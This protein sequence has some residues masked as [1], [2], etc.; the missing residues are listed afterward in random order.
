[1][2]GGLLQPTRLRAAPCPAAVRHGG[3]GISARGADRPAAGRRDSAGP[4]H[5]HDAGRR[6]RAVLQGQGPEAV[7]RGG[8]AHLGAPAR[9]VRPRHTAPGPDGLSDRR[10]PGASARGRVR[11]AEGQGRQAS[12]PLCGEHQP[13]ARATPAPPA[14]RARGVG[15]RPSRRF[16][17]RRSRRAAF[18]GSN[19][20]RSAG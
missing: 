3:G 16:G 14:A 19:P 9:G 7:P 10:L 4:R 2:G 13:P 11:Q 1:V 5:G 18:G 20:T 12:A 15:G 17:S 8:P 6:I